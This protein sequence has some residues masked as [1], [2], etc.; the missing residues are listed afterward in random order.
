MKT[1]DLRIRTRRMAL[2]LMRGDCQET[3]IAHN[4]TVR[5]RGEDVQ[6]VLHH[7]P[8]VT[9]HPEGEVTLDTGGWC[10]ATTK[11]RMN[12]C[13]PFTIYQDKRVWYVVTG[14]GEHESKLVS[15]MS[16]DANGKQIRRL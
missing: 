7:T 4:T 16:F 8:I 15:R 5:L 10:T 13:S 1:R 12:A 11:Q 6:I 9:Y 3:K 2:T 14:K